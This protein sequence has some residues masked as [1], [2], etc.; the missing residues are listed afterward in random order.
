[1]NLEIGT[2]VHAMKEWGLLTCSS[3]L[4]QLA[5][6]ELPG[7]SICLGMTLATVGPPISIINQDYTTQPC[8]QGQSYEAIFST[9]I[10]S[11]QICLS[12]CQVD[13]TN[14]HRCY[15]S[16]DTK[17]ALRVVPSC[18]TTC[19]MYCAADGPAPTI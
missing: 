11:S 12:L 6:L 19:I 1:M 4:A 3:W 2:E 8:L 5:F 9:K 10:P 15:E 17:V 7:P 16:S 14:Q 18:L 13:R